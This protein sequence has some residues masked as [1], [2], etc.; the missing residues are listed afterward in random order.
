MK[1]K[2]EMQIVVTA[3]DSKAKSKL[4]NLAS[5]L[6][7]NFR[8]EE[9][10]EI[11]LSTK[12]AKAKIEDL[13]KEV[14]ELKTFADSLT[15]AELSSGFYNRQL[16]E[17]SSKQNTLNKLQ[18]ALQETNKE[19]IEIGHNFDNLGKNISTSFDH[20]SRK[21]RRF[22]LSLFSLRT[23]WALLSRA[24]STYLSQNETTANKVEA[25][26]V[27]LG[28]L[29][30]PIIERIVSWLQ[31]GIAYL[32]VF[33]KALLGV[34]ILAK[35]INNSVKTTAKEMKKTLSSMDEIVN[36]QQDSG[37]AN[38]GMGVANALEDINNL[39][40]NPKIVKFLEDLANTIKKVWDLAKELWIF[41]SNNFGPAGAALILGGIGLLLGSRGFGGLATILGSSFV[42]SFVYGAITGRE[43]L[44]DITNIIRGFND[45]RD[46]EEEIKRKTQETIDIARNST[47]TL[48]Q[49]LNNGSLS[50]QQIN[51]YLDM[52]K[53]RLDDIAENPAME[54]NNELLKVYAEN[55]KILKNYYEENLKVLDKNTAEY[56]E[57]ESALKKIDDRI[58]QLDG[59]KAEVEVELR[60][61]NTGFFNGLKNGISTALSSLGNAFG[62]VFKS[63]RGYATGGFPNE[64]QMFYA[65]E[66]GPEL[67]GTIGGS[68]AVVNNTQ[69]VDAVSLGV[70]NAVSSV[71]GS[72]RNSS[73][74]ATYLYINGSEFA[75]AVYDD[76]ETENQRRNK[77]TSIR[78]S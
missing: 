2:K 34:D 50:V 71:L 70:A 68:T 56:K 38:N 67:V 41:L 48:I 24:S 44:D 69:I 73:S 7:N 31:Y 54:E 75:K 47:N 25:V 65:N 3:D 23:I 39:E 78:R 42:I 53:G 17:L 29:L 66:R 21:A 52:L 9:T 74:N 11:R 33:T 8:K 26:W 22:V 37:N 72:Q 43:L 59:T 49:N 51:D 60:G 4:E 76:M 19:T 6:K 40:L 55:L 16:K 12:E 13:K 57:Q 58:K 10:Q 5:F 61:N 62:G 30:A 35:A 1:E 32:N 63:L 18:D 46:I 28:N 77:N 20:A 14:S 27:Y 36:L 64:G 45:L 15:S